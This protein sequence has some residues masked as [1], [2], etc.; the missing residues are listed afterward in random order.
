VRLLKIRGF[1]VVNHAR[2][3]AEQTG[4]MKSL[5]REMGRFGV[6]CNAL[7]LGLIETAHDKSWVDTNRDTGE[8]LSN[9]AAWPAL[10]RCSDGFA[11]CVRCRRLD[12]RPSPQHQRRVHYGL[13]Q[14]A[15]LHTELIVPVPELL[16]RHAAI[17]SLPAGPPPSRPG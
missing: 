15:V 16:A 11:S 14:T 2:P 9:Q 7:A 17:R 12:H 4:L 8:A 3:I 6:T 13:R 5:A 10:G 1:R